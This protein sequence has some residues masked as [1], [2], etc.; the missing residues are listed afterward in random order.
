MG[1]LKQSRPRKIVYSVRPSVFSLFFLP[2]YV[3]SFEREM[4]VRFMGLQRALCDLAVTASKPNSTRRRSHT[5]YEVFLGLT[6]NKC[7]QTTALFNK[8]TVA[9][10]FRLAERSLTALALIIIAHPSIPQERER[11]HSHAACAAV[12]AVMCGIRPSSYL[13]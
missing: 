8:H 3:R 2:S 9:Y 12:A 7:V 13:Y 4:L 6:R 11:N 5:C 1:L 10:Q